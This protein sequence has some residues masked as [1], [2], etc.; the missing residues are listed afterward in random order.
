MEAA[1]A[2]AHA[3]LW[4]FL[5]GGG[6]PYRRAR[7]GLALGGGFARGIAH[8]G[9][10]E[11]LEENRIPL[12]AIAG[13][14]AGAIIAAAYA[15]GTSLDR[16][17]DLARRMKFNDVARWTLS[18]MGLMRS[19]RMTEFL[20]GLLAVHRFEE[21]RVPLGIV[22]T[23]LR[24]GESVLFQQRGEVFDAIRASCAY[25]GLFRPVAIDGQL[26]VDGGMSMDVPAPAAKEMG[27]KHVLAVSLDIDEAPS[28][29]SNMAA[30]INRCFQI[31]QSRTR[32]EWE[33]SADLVLTPR[34][35]NF[36]WD[37]FEASGE[38][39]AAGRRAA[40]AALP[41]IRAWMD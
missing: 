19:E 33:P 2:G 24:K 25:P 8:I 22:A 37:S 28:D 40:E 30:V 3:S 6:E 23:D 9:V 36:G 41:A 16:I 29:P 17:R 14:S 32:G 4:R 34:I 18:T 21:M 12:T 20:R 27:A 39:I 1:T 10:L 5:Y 15:S 35:R 38:M 26:L 11:V 13:V 7:I 31:L